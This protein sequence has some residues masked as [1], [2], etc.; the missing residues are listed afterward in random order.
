MDFDWDDANRGHIAAHGIGPEEAERV[1]QNHPLDVTLQ[2]RAGEPR[3]VQLGETDEHRLLVIVTT[4][5]RGKVR[6]VTAFP[7]NARMRRFYRTHRG[8]ADGQTT[9]GS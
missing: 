7:A 2:N 3:I 9:Q 1:V 4:W 8:Q 5:R 6:V